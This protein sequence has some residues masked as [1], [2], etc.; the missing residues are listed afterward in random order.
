MRSRPIARLLRLTPANTVLWPGAKPSSIERIQRLEQLERERLEEKEQRDERRR[1][2]V[3][4]AKPSGGRHDLVTAVFVLGGEYDLVRLVARVQ[5]LQ[6]VLG[7]D[8]GANLLIAYRR[9]ANIVRIE[10]KKDGVPYSA[11]PSA[12]VVRVPE[13]AALYQTLGA[14]AAAIHEALAAER[15]TDAMVEMAGLRGSVDAFFERVTVNCEDR[16]A[17]EQRLRLL[18]Q[19]RGAMNLVADFSK[20]EG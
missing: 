8:D 19:V 9:A 6:E 12:D 10:E 18:W 2:T 20:I 7:T 15:F 16:A 1:Q 4:G 14:A 17:R 13:E 5:A 3:A 11:A